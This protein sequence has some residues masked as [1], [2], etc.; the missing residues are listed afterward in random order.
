MTLS[1]FN[2]LSAE[3]AQAALA[4]CVAIKRW[5]QAMVAARPY[6][7]AKALY[8]QARLLAET[9]GDEDF[10]QALAAHPRI[11]ERASGE[12]KEAALS[13]QEQAAVG[14]DAELQQA[15][16][17][18]NGDYEQRFGH[19]FLIRAKGRSGQEMLAELRRR[20]A[21][22]PAQEQEEA[23]AQLREITLLRLEESIA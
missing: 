14:D 3:Q 9:W 22:T 8:Q 6:A 18:G 12:D 15:L 20:L 2:Q 11:G 16:R 7:S 4:H 23:L 1:Q 17:E 21:N 13:R 5:Q 10:T 19:L